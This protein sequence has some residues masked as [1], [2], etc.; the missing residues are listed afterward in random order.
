MKQ[1]LT[2]AGLN[3][4][5]RGLCG[6]QI[7]FTKF[8]IGNGPE[9]DKTAVDL[10]NPL[11]EIEISKIER[12][13][14]YVTLTGTFKNSEVEDGFS[15]RETGVFAKDP[16]NEGKE[17][18]YGLWC[19][20]DEGKADYVPASEDRVLETQL[21]VLVFVG[22]AENVTATLGESMTYVTV[23]TL[24]K[25]TEDANNPHNVTKEQIGLGNVENKSI[26]EQ[27]PVFDDA[28]ALK[29]NA[30]GEKIGSV[31]AKVKKAIETLSAHLSA[32]NPHKITAGGIG[33]AE[34]VHYHNANQIN[35]GTLAVAR[36]GTGVNTE[37]ELAAKV[38]PYLVE[39]RF[40]SYTGDGTR[41]REIKLGYK[42]SAV[43]LFDA[44]GN[45]SD[46]VNGYAGGL[47]LPNLG[48]SRSIGETTYDNTWSDTYSVMMITNNG[49]KVNSNGKAKSN[50][51]GMS[52]RYIAFKG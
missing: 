36:G 23:T 17:I 52:Y 37:K 30:S 43:L 47:A 18:L 46:D 16:D 35:A 21:D 34:K 11:M 22:E 19:E 49:F 29:A 50:V 27:T 26:S 5:L 9:Q 20:P 4:M 28:E 45:A 8:K 2:D 39:A 40:G 48:V 6:E 31:F 15:V 32:S 3:L 14:T 13:D 33:A 41:G 25:H 44:N 38:K 42:P 24:K 51:E 12:A 10:N 1:F 7:E